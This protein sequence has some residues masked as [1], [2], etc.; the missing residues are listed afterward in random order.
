MYLGCDRMESGRWQQE[1]SF[2]SFIPSM[3]SYNALASSPGIHPWQSL[4]AAQQDRERRLDEKN[5]WVDIKTEG[6]PTGYHCGQD[7][8]DLRKINLI[9]CQ[10]K[11][12]WVVRNK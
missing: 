12:F 1:V 3:L 11:C 9:Y 7:R 6:L 10:L 4:T 5:S 8:L 2:G